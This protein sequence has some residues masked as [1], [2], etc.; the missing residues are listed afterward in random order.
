VVSLWKGGAE[1]VDK[2]PP[3][4]ATV[5]VCRKYAGS[6]RGGLR[7]EGQGDKKKQCVFTSR[8]GEGVSRMC[9]S[10]SKRIA[11]GTTKGA[12]KKKSVQLTK[13]KKRGGWHSWRHYIHSL[14][15]TGGREE[16]KIS[17]DL[18]AKV[19]EALR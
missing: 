18:L 5:A 6:S 1:Q 9:L 8:K 3:K 10:T 11:G 13:K 4:L 14:K 19:G 7:G 16:I 15:I 12:L 17:R 2:T